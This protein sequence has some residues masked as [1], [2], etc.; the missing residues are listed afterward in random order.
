MRA[1]KVEY[2]VRPE[3]AGQNA[4]NIRRVMDAL[5]ASPIDGM[6]YMAFTAEDGHSFVH[7]NVATDDETLIKVAELPEFKEFQAALKASDPL[8]PPSPTKLD[9]VGAGFDF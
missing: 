8:S 1:V 6:R 7:I 5:R 9:L 2:T 4:A 3:F